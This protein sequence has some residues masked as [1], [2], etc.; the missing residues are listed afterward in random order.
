MLLACFGAIAGLFGYQESRL[1]RSRAIV[2]ALADGSA[3]ERQPGATESARELEELQVRI[4][5]FLP[6]LKSLDDDP[7]V[8]E[9]HGRL[10]GKLDAVR[11]QLAT[12]Q[13]QHDALKRLTTET[14]RLGNFRGL[15]N[16]ALF[17]DTR[18]TGLDLPAGEEATRRAS[19]A[20]LD[21]YAA[22]GSGD[23]WALV[24]LHESLSPADRAEIAEGCYELLLVLS[25]AETTP[26]RGLRRLDQAARLNATPTRAYQLRRASCL[27]RAGDPRAADELR[28]AAET[29]QVT[30]ALD[31][32]LSGQERY[33]HNEWIAA[34]RH[35]DAALR[36]RP[37]HF[38]AQCLSAISW[39]QLRRPEA[40]RAGFTACL[41][42]EPEFAWLYIY[43]GF[44][45]SLGPENASP[46][47]LWLR[48]QAAL[49][50]YDQA[51][52]MLKAQAECD[53]ELHR[54][55]QPRAAALTAGRLGC[56]CR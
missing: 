13:S 28:R 3:L 40:A 25:Q 27:E 33:T 26:E 52:E 24:P 12:Y 15:L 4:S 14:Q 21:V 19:V 10:A 22:P 55:A 1:E 29:Q 31:H 42:R 39:L 17:S 48:A 46:A 32:Y 11:S 30:T 49:A 37:N 53:A 38:W 54:V 43:R 51:M 5:G 44:A 7:R 35:F 36:M 20:A 23:S 9:L 6:R 41:K 16:D 47:E 50:D 45:A 8:K 2:A 18:F 56:R 34:I